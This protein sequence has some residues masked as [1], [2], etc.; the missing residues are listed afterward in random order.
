MVAGT[1]V[2]SLVSQSQN[3]EKEIQHSAQQ[4]QNAISVAT[5]EAAKARAAKEVIKSLTAQVCLL[6]DVVYSLGNFQCGDGCQEAVASTHPLTDGRVP[7]VMMMRKSDYL[8]YYVR[9]M[10][11]ANEP[12]LA[13]SY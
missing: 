8:T 5:E 12:G 13:S 2:E 11:A 4:L 9:F 7:S 1:Q 6:S 10:R 3:Q